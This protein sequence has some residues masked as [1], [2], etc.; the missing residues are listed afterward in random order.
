MGLRGAS[1]FVPLMAA[2]FF[3]ALSPGMALLSGAA[4]IAIAC[5]WPILKLPGEG[6]LLG[7]C[8]SAVIAAFDIYKN[9]KTR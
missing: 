1:V 6:I 8:V 5:L 7:I 2:I 3:D 9:K 4:G